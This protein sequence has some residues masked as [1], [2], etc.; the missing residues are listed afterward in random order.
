M[1]L[2]TGLHDRLTFRR[3]TAPASVVGAAVVAAYVVAAFLGFRFASVAEQVTTVWPPTGISLA[4]LL[5]WGPRLWP[6]VWVGALIANA[7][8]NAP[9]W[10]A[11]VVAT[12]NTLEA[13]F[14]T[15]VLRRS[16][17]FDARLQR[18]RDVLTFIL[19]AAAG[20]TIISA[21]VGVG[22][23]AVSGVQLWQR[24]PQLWWEWWVGDAVGAIVVAPVILAVA[25]H[26][27]LLLRSQLEGVLLVAGAAITMHIVFGRV[28]GT[29]ASHHPLEYLIFPFVIAAALRGGQTVTS[30]VVL[31]ASA[32][33]IWNTVRGRGP[34]AGAG[35]HDSLLLLQV[36]TGVLAS[37]G[38]L[39][40]AAISE[41]ETGE[42]RRAAAFAVGEVLARAPDLHAAAPAVLAGICGNLDWQ[43]GGL[44]LF[45]P[46]D[47]RLRCIAQ[48]KAPAMVAPAF[49]RMTGD[50]RFPPGVDLPGRVFATGAVAWID[51]VVDDTNFPRA[52]AARE[53]GLHAAFGFPIR[54]GGEVLGVIDCFNRTVVPR[55]EDL[56]RTM[57]TVGHQVGQFVARKREEQAVTIARQQAEAA[58]RAKDDFLATLSHELRTPLNAIVGWTRMM[59]D[60]M[61][62]ADGTRRALEVIDR[63]AQ[64]Q[65]QLVADLLDVSRIVA[66]RLNLDPSPVTLGPVI[67]AALDA[68][69]PAAEARLVQLVARLTAADVVLE[70]DGQRLQQIVWNLVSN[71]VKFSNPGG[72]VVVELQHVGPA[73]VRL[74]VS[75]DGEGI[76]LEFLA[77]VFERFSQAD[78]SVSRRHGGLGLGLAIVRHL[79]EL[80]GGTIVAESEGPGRGAVFT[81]DLPAGNRP[82][83]EA[84]PTGSTET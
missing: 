69:R 83:E 3:G 28:S 79:V 64:L 14:A 44:W 21:T 59:M 62:D 33:T 40:A 49:E 55:D 18:V 7:A 13:V 81:V 76:E 68:V 8:M 74:R 84:L 77:H 50:A 66:G 52:E 10:T 1:T 75:D 41:R 31:G 42:R 46:E 17:Q 63:N 82:R 15:W 6:A 48:W 20:S 37:T 35:I 30:L 67:E 73:S 54:L 78:L 34:F 16:F 57:S 23:L 71:A 32:V 19:V 36:F 61:L 9:I 43:A 39:L 27:G 58:N 47:Q 60:G 53:A 45:D 5:L 12:G 51:N 26:R 4:A 56:L 38:L 70:G 11:A 24:F 65:T 29:T 25:H 2:T 22:T 72:T 80:H